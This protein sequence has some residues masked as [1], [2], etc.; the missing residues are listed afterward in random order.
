[1]KLFILVLCISLGNICYSKESSLPLP[2]T[3]NQKNL[4]YQWDDLS[5]W[6]YDIDGNGKMEIDDELSKLS[7]Q[8]LSLFFKSKYKLTPKW[9][10]HP[11]IDHVTYESFCPGLR[12]YNL[13]GEVFNA[14]KK[15]IS[16]ET[17]GIYLAKNSS[18]KK[19]VLPETIIKRIWFYK[20]SSNNYVVP[21][22]PNEF[23][24]NEIKF[25]WPISGKSIFKKHKYQSLYKVIRQYHNFNHDH[26]LGCVP[27]K[28]L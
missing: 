27:K 26:K 1:M 23:A 16:V 8:N 15:V 2:L 17:E 5:P 3:V 7:G 24:E 19:L 25:L 9:L 4:I 11:F 28:L 10:M 12:E 13:G 18:G 22:K 6:F 14:L 20:N 21:Q